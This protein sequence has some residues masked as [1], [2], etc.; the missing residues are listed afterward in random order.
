MLAQMDL[1]L[2]LTHT[3]IVAGLDLNFY[4]RVQIYKY[5][6]TNIYKHIH[7]MLVRTH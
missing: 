4:V 3:K 1:L 6:S 5:E 2:I 7:Q